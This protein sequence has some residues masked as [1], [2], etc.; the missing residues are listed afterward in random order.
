MSDGKSIELIVTCPRC[1]TT[2]VVEVP[3]DDLRPNPDT[4][5]MYKLK[6]LERILNLSR[7]TIRQ[8]ISD[9]KLRA[10]KYGKDKRSPWRVSSSDLRAFRKARGDL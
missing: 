2:H 8:Y 6:E 3:L 10:T 4:E 5:K 9:G 7:R 1:N